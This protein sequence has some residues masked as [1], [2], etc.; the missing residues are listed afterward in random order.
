MIEGP[1]DVLGK[2]QLCRELGFDGMELVSPLDFSAGE[3]RRASEKTGMPVHG[4]ST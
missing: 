1:Q 4:W 3:V 2:F